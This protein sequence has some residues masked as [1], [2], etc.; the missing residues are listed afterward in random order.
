VARKKGRKEDMEEGG[1]TEKDEEGGR[2][3][4]RWKGQRERDVH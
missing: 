4:G 2:K 1:K 3:G